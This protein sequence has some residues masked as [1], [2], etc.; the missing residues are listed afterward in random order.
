M[1]HLGQEEKDWNP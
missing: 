1:K